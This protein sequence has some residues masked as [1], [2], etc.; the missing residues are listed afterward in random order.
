M[1]INVKKYVYNGKTEYRIYK[2]PIQKGATFDIETGEIFTKEIDNNKN[3]YDD[4]INT[5]TGEER[6]LESL[7]HSLNSSINRTINTIYEYGYSNTWEWF[8][9]FT[10]SPDYLDRYD[11]SAC[12]K[13]I[14][15]FLDNYKYRYSNELKYLVV[16]EQHKDGAWHFHGL[17]SGVLSDDLIP[18]KKIKGQ[19][20]YN[21][22][23]FKGGYT[24]ATKVHDTKRVATYITKYITKDIAI[25]TKNK[26]RL[27]VSKNLKKPDIVERSMSPEEIQKLKIKLLQQATY[28]KELKVSSTDQTI[29]YI[30]VDK[31]I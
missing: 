13:S 22:P 5:E 21:F 3:K 27:L 8:F 7:D 6:S 1:N 31:E 15:K 10:F 11:Y 28:F 2:K 12:Y 19:M 18:F 14:S 4:N 9:T 30:Q 20:I 16:P 17:L 29:L 25:H 23:R 26:H 24:T